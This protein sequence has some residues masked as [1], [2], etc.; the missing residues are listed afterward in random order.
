M[1]GNRWPGTAFASRIVDWQP[2]RST[3]SGAGSGPWWR[4]GLL[5]MEGSEPS[6]RIGVEEICFFHDAAPVYGVGGLGRLD[7]WKGTD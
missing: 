1:R 2:L 3:P 4:P 5:T 6:D 7:V